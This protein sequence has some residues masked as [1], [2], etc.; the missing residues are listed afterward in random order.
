M[1]LRFL[2]LDIHRNTHTVYRVFRRCGDMVFQF[3][4]QWESVFDANKAYYVNIVIKE[5][6]GNNIARFFKN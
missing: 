5:L 4:F 1:R 6:T 2:C 3:D